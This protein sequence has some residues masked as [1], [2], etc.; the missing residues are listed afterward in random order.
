MPSMTQDLSAAQKCAILRIM[1]KKHQ[2]C[3]TEKDSTEGAPGLYDHTEKD[4]PWF[5]RAEDSEADLPPLGRSRCERLLFHPQEWRAAESALAAD[6]VSLAYDAGR[7]T[8]RLEMLP[9]GADRLALQ[10]AAGLSWWLGDRI[11]AERLGLWLALRLGATGEDAPDVA[12]AAWAARRLAAPRLRPIDRAGDWAGVISGHLGLSSADRAGQG[13]RIQAGDGNRMCRAADHLADACEGLEAM[14]GL[15]PVTFG[16]LGFHLWRMP[17]PPPLG[18]FAADPRVRD[19]EAA[20]L[21]S[22]LAA[23]LGDR[24][25][26]NRG[27]AF[28]PL[29]LTGF[30]ALTANGSAERRLGAFIAGAHQAVLSALLLLKRLSD[31][32]AKAIKATADLSGRTPARLI[33]CLARWPLVS[34][35]LAVAETGASRA[36]VQRNLDVLVARGLAREVTGQG[37]YRVWTTA[38]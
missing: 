12:R 15:S 18:E 13:D 34:T 4:E 30:S 10:E 2:S 8:E 7:L 28:L 33:A 23:G 35:P 26:A 14:A 3:L 9:G 37:R 32:Q 24:S 36:A 16:C 38:L 19:A 27:P 6:L 11:G 5:W 17:D 29:T 21:G 25:S 22:R 1:A 20:V 31:W